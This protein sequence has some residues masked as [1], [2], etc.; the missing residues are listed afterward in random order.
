[1]MMMNGDFEGFGDTPMLVACEGGYIDV[2]KCLFDAGATEDI[3]TA[4]YW[5]E[6]PMY[7]ACSHGHL[8]VAR[9]LYEVGA[10][11]DFR[12]R[13]YTWDTCRRRGGIIIKRFGN[14][15]L[16]AA[17]NGGYQGVVEWLVIHGA[18][19]NRR[20]HVDRNVL[21]NALNPLRVPRDVSAASLEH[22]DH[23]A[24]SIKVRD[25]LRASL[26]L[27]MDEHSA[28]ISLVLA[29]TRFPPLAGT[30]TPPYPKRLCGS[31]AARS[32]CALPLLCGHEEN[33]LSLI[34]GFSGVVRGR[35]L[36]NAREALCALKYLEDNGF[37]G[38]DDDDDED[39]DD[40]DE[41]D[42]SV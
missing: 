5:G 6:T 4:N 26:E 3:G 18:A 20:G 41:D 16:L 11:D 19:H 12:T 2:V 36:R 10:T 9:W 25:G 38:D 1:M 31:Q 15:P 17:C 29:A 33:L 40:E 30:D 39:D 7:A 24:I 23:E 28:F 37:D 22:Y 32:T 27:Q 21:R 35:Q 42:E 34:A 8:D 14:T 13:P